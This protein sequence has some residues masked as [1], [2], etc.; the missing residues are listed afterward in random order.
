MRLKGSITVFI[1]LL[2]VVALTFVSVICESV[3]M[4]GVKVCSVC[5]NDAVCE[6]SLAGYDSKLMDHFGVFGT[7]YE[8]AE[9][10]KDF[11]KT[12]T[13]ANLHPENEFYTMQNTDFYKIKL[14]DTSLEEYCL[15][16]DGYGDAFFQQAV[17][18][19]KSNLPAGLIEI[20][21][22]YFNGNSDPET[23]EQHFKQMEEENETEITTK[24]DEYNKELEAGNNDGNAK[25]PNLDESPI[26][27]IKKL[28]SNG[29]LTFVI[30]SGKTVSDVSVSISE[31]VS[32]RTLEKGI[33][34]SSISS[35]N[36]MDKAYFIQYLGDKLPCFTSAENQAD[37][38]NY[39]LEYCIAGKGS[40]T[41]NLKYVVNK[42]LLIKEATNLV[43]LLSDSAKVAQARALA[44]L[45]VGATALPPLIAAVESGILM[46]WAYA[47]SVVDVRNLLSGGTSALIK[48]SENW[49]L[50]L[51]NIA[52]LGSILNAPV[53]EKYGLNYSSYL[54]LLMIFSDR[55][56]LTMR[57][58]DM[59]EQ[60]MQYL[61]GNNNYRVDNLVTSVTLV[62]TY[63]TESMF[64]NIGFMKKYLYASD[65]SVASRF[66]Y[67]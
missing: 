52:S 58:L 4:R 17:M 23:I 8:G 25:A 20:L 44:L 41:E 7:Y 59:V 48:T 21:I 26:E 19:A 57:S 10:Y 47:E 18:Y 32:Q 1:S 67:I 38:L 31:C 51:E 5:I 45:L 66:S 49:K 36:I 35:D 13:D 22:D 11:I 33:S 53:D 2:L 28:K 34:G 6:S 9:N 65:F 42:L 16:T 40:D 24:L 12:E 64:A 46:A 14:C 56:E 55:K 54:K 39:K 29:V 27:I 60:E 43:Y 63:S 15:L 50:E 3:R 37:Y 61:Y 30:P 62:S